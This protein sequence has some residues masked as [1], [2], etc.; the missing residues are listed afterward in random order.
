RTRVD[1][2]LLRMSELLWTRERWSS[3]E[4]RL[5]FFGVA[6]RLSAPDLGNAVVDDFNNQRA[7][8][9]GLEH[10]IGWFDIAMHDAALFSGGQRARGLLN[11]FKRQGK[12]HWTFATNPGLERFALDQFHDVETFAVLLSVM[13]HTR[14]VRM[15][16][17]RGCSCLAQEARTYAGNSRNSPVDYL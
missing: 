5:S 1:F 17:L 9:I 12:R 13:T 14:D 2:R 8:R 11:H 3:D 16:D 4:T 7:A 15:M 10:D 6:F